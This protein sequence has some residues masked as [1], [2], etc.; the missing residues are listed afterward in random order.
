[1]NL[2]PLSTAPEH[3]KPWQAVIGVLVFVV[4]IATFHGLSYVLSMTEPWA[5]LL[6]LLCWAGIDEHRPARFLPTLLGATA[7]LTLGWLLRWAPQQ[8]GTTGI[9]IGLLPMLF[10]LGWT[11]FR[12]P[13]GPVVNHTLWVFVSVVTVPWIHLPVAF[14]QLYASLA[15]GAAFF[16]SVR[17]LGSW[18][19][20]HRLRRAT[21]NPSLK[22]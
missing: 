18:L 8:F 3:L 7:G 2:S 17:M 5:A 20:K 12:G 9:A 14:P 13:H 4:L 19:S 1:M 10:T 16:G 11:F 15:V 6:W 21:A 22:P